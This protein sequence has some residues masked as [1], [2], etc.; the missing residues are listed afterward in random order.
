MGAGEATALGVLTGDANKGSSLSK[1]VG[2]KKG[3]AGDEA[4]GVAG[5]AGRGALVGAAV[6]SV[7][8][9]V[10]TAI[11]AVAGGIIGAG[12]EL[13]KVF[14]DPNSKLRKGVESFGK[15][16]K[17]KAGQAF[18]WMGEKAGQAWEG[19][20]GGA[21]KWWEFQKEGFSQVASLGK[22]ALGGLMSGAK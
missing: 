21:S 17:E 20:K 13:V 1:Y 8:P 22:K 12:S 5:S 14:S 11:G 15:D 6:G 2:I 16:V 7:V 19:L 3:S 18:S 10:G 9:V 4:M